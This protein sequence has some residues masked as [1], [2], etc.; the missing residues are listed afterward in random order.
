MA[1]FNVQTYGAVGDGTTDDLAAINLALAAAV[2]AGGGAVYFPLGTYAVSNTVVLAGNYLHLF[3]DG[4]GSV[5]KARGGANQENV[6]FALSRTG[7]TFSD[8]VIDANHTG[9]TVI[10]TRRNGVI[11]TTCTDITVL[12][13]KVKNTRGVVDVISAVGFGIGGGTRAKLVG[14]V[15]EDCGVLNDGDSDGLFASGTQI[16]AVASHAYRVTDTGFSFDRVNQSGLCGCTAVT[17]GAG[18]AIVNSSSDEASGNFLNGFTIDGWTSTIGA[19]QIGNPITTSTGHLLDTALS[20]IVIRNVSGTGP[21]LAVRRT[22]SAKTI[23]LTLSNFI[24]DGA[25]TQGLLI[26]GEDVVVTNGHISSDENAVQ[27]QT[28][29]VNVK[30]SNLHLMP[31]SAVGVAIATGC[32][33]IEVGECRIEGNASATTHGVFAF[34]TSTNVRVKPTNEITGMTSAKVGAD[35][36]TSPY[37]VEDV[38]VVSAMPTTGLWKQGQTLL[39]AVPALGDPVGWR[40]TTAGLAPGTAVFSPMGYLVTGKTGTGAMVLAASPTVTGTFTAASVVADPGITDAPAV[41]VHNTADDKPTIGFYRA[42]TLRSALRLFVDNDFRL[43]GSDLTTPA[44]LRLRSLLLASTSAGYIEGVEQASDP[45]A[46]AANSGRAYF[47][48]NGSGKTQFVVRFPT[49]AVQVIATE[50]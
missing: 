18:A 4:E 1:V 39:L 6:I 14:F 15:A 12:N 5:I 19:I 22:G 26:N 3:G 49:G 47:R 20:N 34:G 36:G 24:L 37:S 21:S 23:R 35:N 44:D 25:G 10:T 27:I 45:A 28:G 48:D 8:L 43:L 2:A 33:G 40:V 41:Q 11:L 29:S 31:N 17:V 9:R 46:P 7:L 42:G 16:V 32:D 13:V 38:L 50:P 30:L